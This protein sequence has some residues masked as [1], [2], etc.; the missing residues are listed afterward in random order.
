MWRGLM[1]WKSESDRSWIWSKE[2]RWFCGV[3]PT[4]TNR[5]YSNYFWAIYTRPSWNVA[6]RTQT[7]IRSPP[8]AF[9]G[10]C[11]LHGWF[12]TFQYHNVMRLMCHNWEDA[13]KRIWKNGNC[14]HKQLITAIHS[15][16]RRITPVATEVHVILWSFVVLTWMRD[17]IEL[18]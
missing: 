14:S 15:N 10:L 7:P 18:V 17:A 2:R 13:W 16:L 5:G 9:C 8:D 4:I 1:A 11:V 6:G 3:L 12:L